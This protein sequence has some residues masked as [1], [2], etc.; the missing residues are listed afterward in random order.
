MPII[1]SAQKKVRKDKTRTVKNIAYV[2]AYK[3]TFKKLNKK[4]KN[5]KE[6]ISRYYSQIDKA[7]KNKII[8]K[9]K[10]NRLKSAVKKFIPS[11]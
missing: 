1:K 3:D 8:H 7:V 10:G 6:L 2:K 9:N 4:P 11:K 5:I